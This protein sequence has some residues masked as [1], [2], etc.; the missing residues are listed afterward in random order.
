MNV[1]KKLTT[2][3][4]VGALSATAAV[5]SAA[6]IGLVNMSQVVNSYPGYGALDMKMQ[7]VDAQYRP[8]IEKK[9]AEIE[10]IQDK[11]QAEAEFNKSVAPLLQ[12]EN[13]EINKI[14]EPMM[15]SIHNAVETIRVEKHMDVVLDDPYT[16]RAA[17]KDSKIENIT[18]EVIKR[19]K[20]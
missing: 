3:A 17:D 15:Q 7:Q 12:K 10:K 8:Q 1:T 20:K 14:A 5:A 18:D 11:A 4:I 19:L 9:V 6:N 2:L 16:I 13:E